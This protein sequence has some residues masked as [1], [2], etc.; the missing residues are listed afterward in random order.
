MAGPWEKYAAQEEGP[1]TK[2]AATPEPRTER[3][4]SRG[5]TGAAS[6]GF[7]DELEGL[8]RAGGLEPDDPNVANAIAALAVGSYKKFRGDPE[9]QKAYEEQVAKSRALTKGLE[10][11]HP[12]ASIGGQVGGALALPAAA[13][14]KGAT[15]GARALA[16]GITGAVTGGLTGIGQ[17]EDTTGRVVGGLTGA[18]LG[19]TIGAVAP[20]VVEPITRLGARVLSP[21]TSRISGA[22]RPEEAATQRIGIAATRGPQGLTEAEYAAE[23]ALGTPVAA[24]DRLG[25]AGQALARSA[26]NTS[27]EARAALENVT[28]RYQDTGGRLANWLRGQFHYPD[29]EAQRVA[30]AEAARTANP[31]AYRR[32]SQEAAQLHP[33]GLW[34]EGFE[35]IAQAPEVQSA[36]RKASITGASRAAR[37]GFTPVGNPFRM[38]RSTGRMTLPDG[39]P[40]PTLEFWD[41]V[42][43]N[44]DKV[45]TREAQDWSRVLRERIDELVPTYGEARA[46]AASFF[47]ARDM[48][49]AGERFVGASTRYRIP[50]TR[51]I[52]ANASPQERQLF[53]DGYASRLI[54]ALEARGGAARTN[55]LNR[56]EQSPAARTELELGLGGRDRTDAFLARMRVESVMNNMR[57]ALGNSTT[58]RQLV[59]LGLAGGAGGI[60]YLR[61]GG[62][63]LHG[64]GAAALTLALT[65]GGR[66]IDQRVATRVGELLASP[67]QAVVERGI[68]MI[69]QNPALMRALESADNRVARVLGA[70][71]PRIPQALQAGAPGR[72]E[73]DQPQVPGPPQ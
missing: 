50:E 3:A 31:P 21:I 1:W 59:E 58:A 14:A 32:A 57:N 30:I 64:G 48:L 23:Q 27:P 54:E 13:A 29:A 44:L 63:L 40:R 66:Y 22:L 39:A 72:A 65:R 56:I 47:G 17:G 38:D 53:N 41:Q 49:N 20:A 69:A 18:G 73:G 6:F 71:T 9:A 60:E 16:S 67:D 55:M 37:E 15:L 51:R 35:Q 2:Y 5:F 8:A 19:G 61:A 26:A 43:Q 42:K 34:D 36:I 70:S 24:V 28:T 45:N 68:R 46:G 33:G 11:Q 10:E 4:I 25:Q 12:Y 7:L 52:L 62:D